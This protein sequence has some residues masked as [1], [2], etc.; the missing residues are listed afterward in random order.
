MNIKH[1]L[2]ILLFSCLLAACTSENE[3]INPIDPNQGSTDDT[4]RRE[5]LLTI[6]NKLSTSPTKT[7]G[8][9]PIA[10]EEENYIRSLDVYVFGS[11]T[12]NGP[13]T[14]QELYYYRDDASTI[15]A[16]WAHSFNITATAEENISTALLKLTKGLYVKLYCIANRTQLFQTDAITGAVS[17][18]TL[19]QP[20]TQTNPGQPTNSVTPGIPTEADFL[21]LHSPLIDPNKVDVDTD[22]DKV[23][24]ELENSILRS[25]LPMTGSYVTPLD[26][27]DFSI[28]ARTQLSFK[29]TRMVARFDVINNAEESRFTIEQISMVKGQKG[30]GFF[31]IKPLTTK[32]DELIAYPLRNQSA[33]TQAASPNDITEGAFY[34]WPSPKDDQGYLV[35]KGKYAANKTE[36]V[37][38]S[39]QVPFQ[40]ITNGIGSYIEVAYNH[41]YTI[42]ITKAD[43]YH[44]DF[45]LEVADW[46]DGESVDDYE[47]DNSFDKTAKVVLSTEADANEGAYVLDNGNISVLP[48]DG[49][50]FAFTMGSNSVL[51][52]DI[53]YKTGS[54]EWLVAGDRSTKAASASMET[55]FTYKVDKSKLSGTIL[56]VTIR[57]TNK[58]SGARKEI[59]VV[60]TQGPTI[61]WNSVSDNY[62]TFDPKTMTATIYNV[63][64]QAITLHAL[65][66][67]RTDPETQLETTGSTATVVNSLPWLSVAGDGST[68]E[69]DYTITLSTAQSLPAANA[70]V[71]FTS[72]ASNAVTTVNVKLKNPAITPLKEADFNVDGVINTVD[73][74]GDSGK[75]IVSLLGTLDNS[76]AITITS[77]EGV[78]AEAT[79]GST[80]LEVSTGKTI[81][82]TNG[83]KQTV[84]TAKIKEATGM[85]TVTK[86]DG[87]ITITNPI[88]ETKS[89]I[90]V[91]TTAP[92]PAP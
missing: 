8:D 14:F 20:L 3:L 79:S 54:E 22:D 47:P 92:A 29:L 91:V 71:D 61:S 28:S 78:T 50:K 67:T 65:A 10:T 53:I 66:E 16:D 34:T 7:K 9:D 11:A 1:K 40:Q 84:I 83:N 52:E 72:T 64:Q 56:P 69:A 62:N 90:K 19:F 33:L 17:E 5:V 46:E 82:L 6:K 70:T 24:A 41:R 63:D 77:P 81:S 12:E 86:D 45:T 26:L 75:P 58:A 2:S 38:V 76:V 30:A 59:T 88:D 35:L 48:K 4:G 42:S 73:L 51:T 85:D 25:P 13:Y 60:P 39:Y 27:T 36:N 15:N 74:T 23:M 87:M 31:P 43:T 55:T 49:S 80:W 37:D 32:A 18:Y 21:K 57:L 68:A 89:T 44:L